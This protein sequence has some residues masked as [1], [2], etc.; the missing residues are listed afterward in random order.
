MHRSFVTTATRSWGGRGDRQTNQVFILLLHC[1]NSAG[2]FEGLDIT[3]TYQ[4]ARKT[5]MVLPACCPRSEEV[6]AGNCRRNVSPL[7][8]TGLGEWL[9]MTGA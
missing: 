3:R 1:P 4:T 5:A 8:S 9:Q 2:V 7:C 6:I